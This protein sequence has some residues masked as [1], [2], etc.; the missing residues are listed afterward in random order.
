MGREARKNAAIVDKKDHPV[1]VSSLSFVFA[2]TAND[3]PDA[4]GIT[5]L[6][7]ALTYLGVVLVGCV[8]T[9]C[10]MAAHGR[11][12]GAVGLVAGALVMMG[13]GGYFAIDSHSDR[14]AA[15]EARP[16][17]ARRAEQQRLRYSVAGLCVA[18][19]CR[20]PLRGRCQHCR[21]G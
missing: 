21:L 16:C 19:P 7:V 6:V 15:Y 17:V 18:F 1:H 9:A 14:V 20:C 2:A 5:N 13:V 12:G 10:C 8:W 11:P 4:P 3:L